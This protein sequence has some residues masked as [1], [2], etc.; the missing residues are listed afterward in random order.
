MGSCM[1][2]YQRDAALVK[3]F[4]DADTRYG[5]RFEGA[6]PE[7]F[8]PLGVTVFD[9]Y[10]TIPSSELGVNSHWGEQIWSSSAE[11][12]VLLMEDSWS[13]HTSQESNETRHNG[14]QVYIRFDFQN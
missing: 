3:R 4:D 5:W 12:N 14:F 11:P 9:G 6:A 1:P 10:D 7:G 2:A 13:T 8:S